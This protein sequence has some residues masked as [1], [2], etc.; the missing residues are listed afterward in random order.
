M[1]DQ[2][3]FFQRDR[4]WHPPAFTPQYKTSVL[5]SPQFA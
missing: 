5:R 3:S 2:G 1:S 4:S